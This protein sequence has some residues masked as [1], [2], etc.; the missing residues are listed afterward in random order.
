MY[1][2]HDADVVR[3]LQPFT[4]GQGKNFVVVE[5]AVE[6]LG[7]V[8]VDISVE[9]DPVPPRLFAAFVRQHLDFIY[10]TKKKLV[11]C[12]S[13]PTIDDAPVR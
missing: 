9:D 10:I 6:V 1:L 12:V 4:A 8:R 13:S 5:H 7:P 11:V 2:E 3:D